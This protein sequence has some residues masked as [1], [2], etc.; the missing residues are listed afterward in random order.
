MRKQQ[1]SM[2]SPWGQASAQEQ[3]EGMAMAQAGCPRLPQAAAAAAAGA[4]EPRW[5]AMASIR[6]CRPAWTIS[7]SPERPVAARL[8]ASS[9]IVKMRDAQVALRSLR[10]RAQ[11]KAHMPD[12]DIDQDPASSPWTTSQSNQRP[13]AD[14]CML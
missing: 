3:G 7:E 1:S 12:N 9:V 8:Q 13:A 4:G 11:G 2:L 14:V 6:T 5:L 10:A